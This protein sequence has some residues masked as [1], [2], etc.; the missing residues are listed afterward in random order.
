MADKI[1]DYKLDPPKMVMYPTCPMCGT[2]MYDYLVEDIC[3]DVIGCSEC[4]K[5]I[6]AEEYMEVMADDDF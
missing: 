6:S 3:G 5:A 2:T 1:P 4:T